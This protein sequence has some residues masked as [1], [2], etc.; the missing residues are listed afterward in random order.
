M[1]TAKTIAARIILS[2]ALIFSFTP[3]TASAATVTDDTAAQFGAGTAAGT[4]VITRDD[5]EIRL[6]TSTVGSYDEEIDGSNDALSLGFSDGIAARADT[7]K[8][9]NIY[10]VFTGFLG[11]DARVY[12]AGSR[13]GGVNWDG[14]LATP[15]VDEPTLLPLNSTDGQ[16][17]AF[18][19]DIAVDDSVSPPRAYVVFLDDITDVGSP[20]V[21]TD[22]HVYTTSMTP[23][24]SGA[25]W[26]G[27]RRV[28]KLA[29]VGQGAA[30][31]VG[32]IRGGPRVELSPTTNDMYVVWG[33]DTS[34]AF[35]Y[36]LYFSKADRTSATGDFIFD[37]DR[38]G[39]PCDSG[40]SPC[41]DL[42]ID[43]NVAAGANGLSA[44]PALAVAPDNTVYVAYED[45]RFATS[46]IVNRDRSIFLVKFSPTDSISSPPAVSVRVDTADSSPD[47]KPSLDPNIALDPTTAGASKKVFI[48]Y[49][50]K[51][52]TSFRTNISVS[53]DN[54]TT[55]TTTP[56]GCVAA[57]VGDVLWPD[58]AVDAFG[59]AVLVHS[60]IAPGDDVTYNYLPAGSS[61][62]Q[63]NS[64]VLPFT[65]TTSDTPSVIVNDAG[66]FIS[67]WRDTGGIDQWFSA[68][69]LDSGVTWNKRFDAT[70]TFTSRI[71][72]LG[73]SSVNPGNFLADRLLPGGGVAGGAA[74]ELKFQWR[75]AAAQADVTSQ[76][77]TGP[78]GSG[79]SYYTGL[80]IESRIVNGLEQTNLNLDGKRYVQYKATLGTGTGAASGLSPYIRS[81]SLDFSGDGPLVRLSGSDRYGTAAVISQNKF[82]PASVESLVVAS[83]EVFADALPGGPLSGLL[84]GPLLLT[85]GSS[86]PSA[87]GGEITRVLQTDLGDID[88]Y[89]LGGD[90]SVSADVE[91]A[92][93][94][95][96]PDIAVKRIGGGN[97]VQT[98]KLIAEEM[99]TIRT[100]KGLGTADRAF[101]SLSTNFP[102]A[103]AAS[104]PGSSTSV[105]SKNISILLTGGSELDQMIE[106]YL[107]AKSATLS[108]VYLTG[109]T[110]ALSNQVFL[111]ADAIIGTAKR[112][113]GLDRYSTAAAI[114][115]EFYVGA[116][117][118][119]CVGVATGENF[120]D[121]LAGGKHAGSK[122]CPIVLV[123][124]TGVPSATNSYVSGNAGTISGGF[125]Y[126]GIVPIP[127][128]VKASVESLY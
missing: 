79:G 81:I 124:K 118:P 26:T 44:S 115:N 119:A 117:A 36:K 48:V 33:N 62:W 41:Q 49:S 1:K 60:E 66:D 106:D 21:V 70:G 71:L 77:F 8:F 38:S 96:R 28:N 11:T 73:D 127:D 12:F 99:D 25:S 15:G 75:G 61:T 91:T 18:L 113:S 114:N 53:T 80:S 10:A 98:S 76:T 4:T 112:L 86:L 37:A 46:P 87:T 78:D 89:L 19:P 101:I 84:G 97:R 111:D 82:T 102:D 3:G 58:I 126:G 90:A 108:T 93:K 55:F 95:L 57:C 68:A 122:N 125:V 29:T 74:N 65:A 35:E 17:G 27:I 50:Q 7:D 69:S 24:T 51:D 42:R 39:T 103:L 116:L 83:G 63:T 109:G 85:R 72:D 59:N 100:S 52:T 45:A 22:S 16:P 56:L 20:G 120:P 123:R 5:G 128:S 30:N 31:Q 88:V 67:F 64:F 14:D 23:G 32:T 110:A 92:I 121:A 107:S 6:S 94:G 105:N 47:I 34:V 13:D 104:G 54:G 43:D 9:G 40:T 2:G